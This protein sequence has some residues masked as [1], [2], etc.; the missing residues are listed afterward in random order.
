MFVLVGVVAMLVFSFA[1]NSDMPTPFLIGVGVM[2]VVVL[3]LAQLVYHLA[4]SFQ[5]IREPPYGR[6]ERGFEPV[7][8]TPAMNQPA[9]SN[10]PI[11]PGASGAPS[12]ATSPPP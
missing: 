10:Q 3:A 7:M 11:E 1:P 8:A 9:A 2:A 6:D 5:A 12:D 4:R